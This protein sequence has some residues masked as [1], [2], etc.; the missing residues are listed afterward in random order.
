MSGI[1]GIYHLD[2]S[3]VE[4]ENLVKMVDILAHRGPDGAD[5]W[6]EGAVGFGHRMLW[7]TPESLL[8]KL[9]LVNQTRDLVITSDARIDNRDELISVLHLDK[10]PPDKITDSQLILAAY[11]KWGEQ[12]PEHLLGDF[13]FAIWDKRQQKLFCA[14]DHFGVKPFYYYLSSSVLIFATEIKAILCLSG[15][16]CRLNEVKVAEHLGLISSSATVTFYEDILRLPAAHNLTVSQG[17]TQILSYWSL[18]PERELRLNSDQEYA[19]AFCKIFT[20]AV[21]CRLR[22]AFPVGSMLSG[23][24]DSSSITCVARKLLLEN[25]GDK[26]HTF[27]TIHEQVIECDERFYQDAVLAQGNLKAH[28]L[29]ADEYSPLAELDRVLWH[30]DEVQGLGNLYGNWFLYNSASERGVRVILDGFDG[31]TTVSHGKGYLIELARAGH[32]FTLAS[33]VRALSK[34]LNQPWIPAFKAWVWIYGLNPLL[35]KFWLLSVVR[36]VLHRFKSK[37]KKSGSSSILNSG[38]IR[39]AL[40]QHN[41]TQL[42]QPN[43]ERKNHYLRLINPGE[44]NTLEKLNSAAAAFSTEVSFPFWDKRLVEFCLSLPPEQKLN[45]GWGR[46]VMR[47]AMEGILPKEIQWRGDKT[48]HSASFDRGLLEFER[49]RLENVI[50]KNP[51]VIKKYVNL[52]ALREAYCRYVTGKVTASEAVT[53][54]K[55]LSL[56]LW[57]GKSKLAPS[58]SPCNKA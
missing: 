8:E 16:P 36:Q 18:N 45:Q 27:S 47:R 5:I 44:Q 40:V 19:L 52:T 58:S 3:P 12:C 56:A 4:R 53:I 6:L 28:R 42:E 25:E 21:C 39:D 43:T 14:R 31:D 22:S 57:L 30:Q 54:W 38:F 41:Q 20:E 9:P 33:Q 29:N 23:G 35:S 15:V 11:E 49:E 7:T 46:L 10:C 17:K 2:D 32:W 13:A 51:E 24:L 37:S 55:V 48:D 50:L 26:L 34:N 1:M